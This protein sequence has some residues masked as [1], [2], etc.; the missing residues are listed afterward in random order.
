[1]SLVFLGLAIAAL[2]INLWGAALAAQRWIADYPVARVTGV[3]AAGLICFFLEHFAGWGPRPPL[4]PFTT[5]ASVWLIWRGRSVLRENWMTEA[6]FGGGFLYCLAWRYA[7]PDI[8]DSG[9][10]MPNLA[11]IEGYMRG[12]RLPAPDVWLAPYRQ[13]FYY[14]FQHY[15]A[16]FLGRMVDLTPGVSYHLAYCTLAGFITVLSCTCIARFCSWSP[17]R[18]VGAL[19]LLL[20]GSGAAVAA[21]VLLRHPGMFESLRFLGGSVAHGT[22]SALG[23]DASSLMATVGVNPSDLPMEPV[24]Y[25]LINGDYHPTLMGYVLLALATTLIASLGGEADARRRVIYHALLGATVPLALI[26]DA[27]VFPL[28]FVLVG[29]WFVYRAVSGDRGYL[30]PGLVGAGAAIA[31]EYPYLIEFMQQ[32]Y[33]NNVPFHL[34]VSTNPTPW[35][36]WIMTFWPV[37]AI[38]LLSLFNRD[39]RSLTIFLVSIWSVELLLSEWVYAHDEY[40]R[41]WMRFNTA[42]K[43]WPWVYAGIV[44]TL[45]ARNLGSSSRWCRIGT[46]S[47][48]IPTLAFAYDIGVQF[49][50]ADKGSM[51]KLDGNAWITDSAVRDMITELGSRPDGVCLESGL[52]FANTE[53]PATTLFG[54]KLSLLG[55]PWHETAWRGPSHEIRER[56]DQIDAFYK[57]TIQ[58]PLKWLLQ[59]NVTY[60]LWLPRDAQYKFRSIFDRIKSRY[61]WHPLY[62]DD[63]DRLIGFWEQTEVTPDAVLA[64]H[65]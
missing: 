19:S 45:G 47:L 17:G 20:G 26:S 60:V 21:H 41:D 10:R 11:M 15:G 42:L 27:W 56:Q 2:W 31:L 32:A 18:W 24:S 37:A 43:W 30:V 23:R 28:Q 16:S 7:F 59:N 33:S 55:W 53:S 44:L 36:G 12:T 14:S 4:L 49:E 25:V 54:G 35:L 64:N 38:M 22:P 51:G 63:P 62:A 48:L 40:S 34:T 46:L 61:F 8:D 57:G 29:G 50:T 52:A 3:I 58:D 9:E 65:D 13:N 5:A 39:R 6:Q 1:M